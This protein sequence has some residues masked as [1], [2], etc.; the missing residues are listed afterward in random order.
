MLDV[1]SKFLM[2]IE[3][4]LD[5]FVEAAT[6]EIN[7]ERRHRKRP[8]VP[9]FV[10]ILARLFGREVEKSREIRRASLKPIK[11]KMKELGVKSTGLQTEGRLVKAVRREMREIGLESLMPTDRTLDRKLSGVAEWPRKRKARKKTTER[12]LA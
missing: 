12:I 11:M 7:P 8:P 10:I 9:S 1:S 2:P 3:P 5:A 6:I 4:T